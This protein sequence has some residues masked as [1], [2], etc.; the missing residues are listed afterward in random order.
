[1]GKLAGSV[2]E[3]M[4]REWGQEL[5]KDVLVKREAEEWDSTRETVV[6]RSFISNQ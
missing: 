5:C 6:S 2:E 1:M 4:V 3:R